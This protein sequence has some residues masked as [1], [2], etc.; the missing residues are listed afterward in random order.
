MFR[1]DTI[2]I[3]QY[4]FSFWYIRSCSPSDLLI[5]YFLISSLDTG[6][7]EVGLVV[8]SNWKEITLEILIKAKKRTRGRN[9][10]KFSIYFRGN[11]AQIKGSAGLVAK[12]RQKL[13]WGR[14]VKNDR[15]SRCDYMS[16]IENPKTSKTIKSLFQG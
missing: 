1:D 11:T 13:T 6:V 5:T 12:T 8:I 14:E 9:E 2:I 10:S 3:Y 15:R 4:L 7:I 16:A